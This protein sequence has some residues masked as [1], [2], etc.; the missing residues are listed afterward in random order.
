MNKLEWVLFVYFH[1]RKNRRGNEEACFQ[2]RDLG[3][4]PF[5]WPVALMIALAFH[6]GA[7]KVAELTPHSLAALKVCPDVSPSKLLPKANHC[8]QLPPGR[9]ALHV[10]WR[11]DYQQRPIFRT[12]EKKTGV[13][14]Q[15]KS[16]PYKTI[17][18]Q[19]EALGLDAGYPEK[20]TPYTFRRGAATI[21]NSK[22]PSVV[23]SFCFAA[24]AECSRNCH[25]IT[26]QSHLRC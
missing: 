8:C 11:D 19:V 10:Q 3:D 18:A 1:K 2:L 25:N 17:H 6:D 20:I 22:Y 5:T 21:V 24:K 7:F 13:M 26:S 15:S 23:Y 12:I 9:K 16:L 14:S 4:D